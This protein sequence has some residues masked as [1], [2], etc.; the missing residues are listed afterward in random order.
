VTPHGAT[1][2][3]PLA[4]IPVQFPKDPAEDTLSN[5]SKRREKRRAIMESQALNAQVSHDNN[6]PQVNFSQGNWTVDDIHAFK[7][8]LHEYKTVWREYERLYGNRWRNDRPILTDSGTKRKAGNR[9]SK[10]YFDRQPIFAVYENL[11][12]SG[13]S[14]VAATEQVIAIYESIL[15]STTGPNVTD[16]SPLGVWRD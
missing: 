14:E 12:A 2:T 15:P 7:R 16:Q 8:L 3:V 6:V 11:L 4:P 10:Y 13:R 5:S 9:H 1:A